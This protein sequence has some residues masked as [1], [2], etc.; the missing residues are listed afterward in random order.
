[1]IPLDAFSPVFLVIPLVLLI[2]AIGI[3]VGIVLLI[4]RLLMNHKKKEQLA[5]EQPRDHA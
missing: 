4:V 5:G 1:M 2:I 3:I